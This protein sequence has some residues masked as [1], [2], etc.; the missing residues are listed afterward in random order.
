ML[1]PSDASQEV[2]PFY[3]CLSGF[4]QSSLARGKARGL[5][6]HQGLSSLPVLLSQGIKLGSGCS[7]R[8]GPRTGPQGGSAGLAHTS[9][10]P[11][12]PAPAPLKGNKWVSGCLVTPSP[13]LSHSPYFRPGS[14][15]RLLPFLRACWVVETS[16]RHGQGGHTMPQ[17]GHSLRN[18][19]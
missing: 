2:P 5:V 18:H 15:A 17:G 14:R 1:P 9:A 11:A 12:V 19:V 16:Q 6:R 10:H 7:R 4:H 3:P 13:L 8:T